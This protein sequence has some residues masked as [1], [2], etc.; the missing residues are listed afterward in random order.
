MITFKV[1]L[2]KLSSASRKKVEVK[3]SNL[4]ADPELCFTSLF[5]AALSGAFLLESYQR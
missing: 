3:C 2:N 4:G 5:L 1:P